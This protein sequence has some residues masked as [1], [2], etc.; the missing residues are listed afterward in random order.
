MTQTELHQRRWLLWQAKRREEDRRRDE[1]LKARDAP[2]GE[3]IM[4]IG[5]SPPPMA[6]ETPEPHLPRSP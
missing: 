3:S 2:A 4:D 6:A 5:A 1:K